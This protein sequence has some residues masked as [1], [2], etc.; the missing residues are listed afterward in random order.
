VSHNQ[1]VAR[2]KSSAAK[3]GGN[4]RLA[5]RL[6]PRPFKTTTFSA[7]SKGHQDNAGGED[8]GR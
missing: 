2:R 7:P 5:A 1:I 8:F 6:K 3:A 4:N